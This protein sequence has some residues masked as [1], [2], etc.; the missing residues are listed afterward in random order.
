MTCESYS[1]GHL[2]RPERFKAEKS[3]WKVTEECAHLCLQIGIQS[4][5]ELINKGMSVKCLRFCSRRSCSVQATHHCVR[6]SLVRYRGQWL[7]R[8]LRSKDIR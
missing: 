4:V 8:R 1:I 3:D 7:G 6:P 5:H 2:T